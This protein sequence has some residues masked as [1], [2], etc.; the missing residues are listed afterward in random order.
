MTQEQHHQ[1]K[2]LEQKESSGTLTIDERKEL[3]GLQ[4]LWCDARRAEALEGKR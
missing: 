4:S 2:H 3:I 1:M